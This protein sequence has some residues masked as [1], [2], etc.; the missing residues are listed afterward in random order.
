M[1]IKRLCENCKTP[2]VTKHKRHKYCCR[3]CFKKKYL[4]KLK[5][6]YFPQYVCQECGYKVTLTFYPRDNPDKWMNLVC[7]RC[8]RK[9]K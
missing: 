1:L 2:F 5:I 6:N 8:K 3:K 4:E 9:R 7:P